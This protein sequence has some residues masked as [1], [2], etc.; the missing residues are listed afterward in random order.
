MLI[1]GRKVLEELVIGD[2]IHITLL[3]LQD[4]IAQLAIQAPPDIKVDRKEVRE[5]KL[6]DKQPS[7]VSSST[8]KRKAFYRPSR[9]TKKTTEEI[10]R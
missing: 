3:S 1:L 9:S 10:I 5:R 8:T 4:G 6:K 2:D 7:S